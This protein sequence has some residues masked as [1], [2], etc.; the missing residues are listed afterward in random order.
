VSEAYYYA[1]L[2]K[3]MRI[4]SKPPTTN[5][6]ETVKDAFNSQS[7]KLITEYENSIISDKILQFVKT[8]LKES[9]FEIGWP[10][11]LLNGL[12]FLVPVILT[13]AY[14]DLDNIKQ[15]RIF[16]QICHGIQ[17]VVIFLYLVKFNFKK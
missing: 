17:V 2:S 8:D 13:F 15:Y 12:L 1:W 9:L 4:N 5:T 11:K 14:G 16:I 10:T 7:D 3:E 6:I